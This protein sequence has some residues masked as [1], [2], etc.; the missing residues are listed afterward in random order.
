MWLMLQQDEPEDFV[1]A[2]GVLHSVRE[3]VDAAFARVGLDPAE[4]VVQDER[5]IRPAEMHDL[6]GDASKAREKLG[7]E[8]QADF[9]ELVRLM[10]DHDLQLLDSGLAH[11]QTG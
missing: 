7:W 8:P 2:T 10:V 3:F 1:I 9:D 6:V 5:F 4:Y 11:E